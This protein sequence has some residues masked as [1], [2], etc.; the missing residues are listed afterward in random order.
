MTAYDTQRHWST[1]NA[2]ALAMA[3]DWSVLFGVVQCVDGHGMG[4]NV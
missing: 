2:V 1:G 4:M 3:Y